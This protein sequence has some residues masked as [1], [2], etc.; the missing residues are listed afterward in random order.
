MNPN[1]VLG[2]MALVATA[3]AAPLELGPYEISGDTDG[4]IWAPIA[5]NR[6]IG[7][8]FTTTAYAGALLAPDGWALFIMNDFDDEMALMKT[9]VWAPFQ[10][11]PI[12]EMPITIDG[13]DTYMATDG[14]FW[15]TT[16]TL[17]STG[18]EDGILYGEDSIAV[19]MGGWDREGVESF[20][21]SITVIKPAP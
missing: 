19:T 16:W 8:G 13:R 17:Q 1:I 12:E 14:R 9:D 4:M 6:G 3:S 7:N 21:E 10:G 20:L 5:Q 18:W 11:A 2:L 15:R